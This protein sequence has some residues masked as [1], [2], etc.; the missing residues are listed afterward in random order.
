MTGTGRRNDDAP[1]MRQSID[2]ELVTV[3]G[4]NVGPGRVGIEADVALVRRTGG[5]GK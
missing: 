4:E 3:I 5:T 2:D 1:I